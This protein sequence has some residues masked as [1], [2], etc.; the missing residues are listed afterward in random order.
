MILII[1]ALFFDQQ[2]ALLDLFRP[3]AN[4]PTTYYEH[5]RNR[6]FPSVRHL[7]HP[8]RLQWQCQEDKIGDNVH[9][10]ECQRVRAVL[11][12]PRASYVWIP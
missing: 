8:H 7:Q 9:N 5:C 2:K 11:Q 4:I 10:A 1:H 12:T 6:P 3:L